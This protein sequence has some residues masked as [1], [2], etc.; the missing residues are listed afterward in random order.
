M[1]ERDNNNKYTISVN[2]AHHPNRRRFTLAHEIGH[3][4]LH[5]KLVQDGVDDDR[6]YRST[7]AGKY[8]NTLIGP[9]EETEANKFAASVLMPFDLIKQV[10]SEESTMSAG[11]LARR[12]GVSEHAM[13]IRLDSMRQQELPF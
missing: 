12:F 9:R 2:A 6:A 13:E 10:A 7:Q 8:H 4:I 3:Y 1:L 5:R 11:V